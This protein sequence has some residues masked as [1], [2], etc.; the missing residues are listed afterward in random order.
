MKIKGLV[1]AT[2]FALSSVTAVFAADNESITAQYGWGNRAGTF[3]SGKH[4]FSGTLTADADNKQRAHLA[5]DQTK[6]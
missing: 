1:I 2:V 6:R 5:K 3:Q 4:N